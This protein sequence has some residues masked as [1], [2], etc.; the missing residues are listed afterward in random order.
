MK[1]LLVAACSSGAVGATTIGHELHLKHETEFELT[2]E[3]LL[4]GMTLA[5]SDFVLVQLASAFMM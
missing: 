3:Q 2:F 1:C 4:V 5:R